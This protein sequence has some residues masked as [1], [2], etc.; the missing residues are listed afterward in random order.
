MGTPLSILGGDPKTNYG[1]KG[2]FIERRI[3]F[4]NCNDKNMLNG[5]I[6]T[7]QI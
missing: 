5:K 2:E 4:S 7:Y 3:L 6:V 1:R